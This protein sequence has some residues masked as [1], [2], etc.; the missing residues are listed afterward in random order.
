MENSYR[1]I[2]L[3]ESQEYLKN[4]STCLVKLETNPGDMES[5]NEI[6][7][8]AHTLK[9]MS[10]TMGYDAIAKLSHQMED[11]LDELRGKRK[12]VTTEIIDALFACLDILERL[13]QDVALK[14]DSKIDIASCLQALKNFL[15]EDPQ[16]VKEKP[17]A[18]PPPAEAKELTQDSLARLKQAKEKGLGGFKI[19]ITISPSCLMKEARAFLIVTHLKRLGE[20]IHTW[21]S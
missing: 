16:A 4:I 18:A 8:Y 20:I 9:G 5:L 15:S 2:F 21:P 14:Q 17:R 7:R 19:K 6:F 1:E 11:L 10:A 3:S 12:T 13:L